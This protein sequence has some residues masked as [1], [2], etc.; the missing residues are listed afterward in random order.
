MRSSGSPLS[1]EGAAHEVL[2]SCP[3]SPRATCGIRRSPALADSR[4]VSWH[5]TRYHT[6]LPSTPKRCPPYRINRSHRADSCQHPS[7]NQ[8]CRH[9]LI[10]SRPVA[11]HPPTDRCAHP[12]CGKPFPIAPLLEVLRPQTWH[13]RWHPPMKR[14][15]RAF[16]RFADCPRRRSLVSST[17]LASTQR[18]Y[19]SL[20]TSVRIIQK[21]SSVTV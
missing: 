8:R 15:Q 4:W 6:N 21:P 14:R 17:L 7:W 3:T 13:N 5:S 1:A 10:A 2:D 9:S 20:V 12:C 11:A 16:W 19:C 18:A